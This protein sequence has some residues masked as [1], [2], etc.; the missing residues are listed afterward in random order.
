MDPIKA[1]EIINNIVANARMG[2]QDHMV[3]VQAL[4]T[5]KPAPVDQCEKKEIVEDERTD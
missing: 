4:E 1:F 2:R 3:A 5:L